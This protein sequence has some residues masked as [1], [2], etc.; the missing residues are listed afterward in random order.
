MQHSQTSQNIAYTFRCIGGQE[1]HRQALLWAPLAIKRDHALA[2]PR[3]SFNGRM[4][5]L[6][7]GGDR[8]IEKHAG[9]CV[10]PPLGYVPDQLT[11]EHGG[12]GLDHAQL[13]ANSSGTGMSA[14]ETNLTNAL[15]SIGKQQRGLVAGRIMLSQQVVK[16][17]D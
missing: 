6:A 15:P 11:H 7:G 16:L 13:T 14:E 17:V 10:V 2:Q 5:A 4:T 9:C 12:F 3:E 1:R 8:L